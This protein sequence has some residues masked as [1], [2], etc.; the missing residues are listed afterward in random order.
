M[1]VHVRS[2]GPGENHTIVLRRPNHRGT[3]LRPASSSHAP[4]RRHLVH[5]RA[6]VWCASRR[7]S[8]SFVRTAVC[9]CVGAGDRRG[10]RV[11]RV[12]RHF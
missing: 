5:V 1:D 3:T 9:V 6:P 10:L 8:H 2:V 7:P 11:A 4:T 12:R